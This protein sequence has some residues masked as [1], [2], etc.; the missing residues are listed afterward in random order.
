MAE[1]CEEGARDLEETRMMARKAR[2]AFN[3]FIQGA[4]QDPEFVAALDEA[5]K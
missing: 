1:N 5:K 2:S 3:I 4:K